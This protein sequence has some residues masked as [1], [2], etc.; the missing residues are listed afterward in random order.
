MFNILRKDT[1]RLQLSTLEIKPITFL[2]HP[3]HVYLKQQGK[4]VGR[5]LVNESKRDVRWRKKK[6][7]RQEECDRKTEQLLQCVFI[8]PCCVLLVSTHWHVKPPGDWWSHLGI[9]VHVVTD[10]EGH[11]GCQRCL[12]VC[13][14]WCGQRWILYLKSLEDEQGFSWQTVTGWVCLP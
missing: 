2:L 5:V 1:F 6:W 14:S 4:A 9:Y 13:Y 11:I 8:C 7:W 3:L 10:R 12:R